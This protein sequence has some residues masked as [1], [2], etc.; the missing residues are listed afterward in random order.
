M[1]TIH[2]K[3]RSTRQFLKFKPVGRAGEM[4]GTAL[5]DAQLRALL[6][7]LEMNLDR[8]ARSRDP[9]TV[10]LALELKNTIDKIRAELAKIGDASAAKRPGPRL[11][12]NTRN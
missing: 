11:S 4:T 5:S 12:T 1:S 8:L 9:H 2:D 3:P 10:D 6:A 7:S